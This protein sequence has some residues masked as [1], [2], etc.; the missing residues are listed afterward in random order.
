MNKMVNKFLNV[1]NTSITIFN[2]KN[3]KY[4]NLSEMLK[5]QESPLRVRA[6]FTNMKSIEFFRSLG[7]NL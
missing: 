6:W 1:N 3:E 5:S 4:V 2:S 7:A